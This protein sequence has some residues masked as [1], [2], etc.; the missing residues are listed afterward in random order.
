[1][2]GLARIE[3]IKVARGKDDGTGSRGSCHFWQ[4]IARG[5]DDGIGPPR[6]WDNRTELHLALRF[7]RCTASSGPSASV[8]GQTKCVVDQLDE[9]TNTAFANLIVRATVS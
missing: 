2:K 4:Q 6:G 1:M 5:A 7:S 3:P 9:Y 8:P